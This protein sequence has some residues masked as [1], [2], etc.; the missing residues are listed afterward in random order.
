MP[1][2][3]SF[4]QFERARSVP[5][6]VAVISADS[7]DLEEAAL[8]LGAQKKTSIENLLQE[9][10]SSSLFDADARYHLALH[11]KITAKEEE[12]LEKCFQRPFSN[13]LLITSK[14]ALPDVVSSVF[15]MKGALVQIAAPKPWEEKAKTEEWI[16]NFAK[17]EKKSIQ[18]EAVS[19]LGRECATSRQQLLQELKKLFLYTSAKNEVTL[20]DVLAIVT[21]ESKPLLWDLGDALL[22]KNVAKAIEITTTGDFS[23]FQVLRYIRN[24]FHEA[25][26]MGLGTSEKAGKVGDKFRKAAS[27]FGAK[28][29]QDALVAIDSLE[30]ELKNVVRDEVLAL[31]ML[32]ITI[33]V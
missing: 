6:L 26:K 20:D 14:K 22:E 18:K 16:S 17:A 1:K 28:G 9:L 12:L 19:L 7:Y 32:M 23:V 31:E 21:I 10:S 27:L 29:L 2:F 33:C 8:K 15:E 5:Q 11:D 3:T 24:Q 4:T 13:P 25:L 30:V